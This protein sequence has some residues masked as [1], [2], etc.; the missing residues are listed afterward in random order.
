M[1]EDFGFPDAT[2][3]F[4]RLPTPI[5]ASLR[6]LRRVA[7]VL[8]LV[9]KCHGSGASWK[10]LQLLNWAVRDRRNAALV[11][12]LWA[13]SDVPDR[14]VV[15]FEPALERAIDLA[16][17]LGLA[18]VTS[19]HAI[20]LTPTGRAALGHIVGARVFE[21]ER[22]ILNAMPGPVTRSDIDLAFEWRRS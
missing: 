1:M 9:A 19:T 2:F 18:A 16:V 15:R 12:A 14:P 17:G 3:D 13:G 7:L 21:T 10:G 22:N 8:L 5:P 20:K 11:N 4:T 6:P